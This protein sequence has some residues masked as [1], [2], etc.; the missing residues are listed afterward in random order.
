MSTSNAVT[1]TLLDETAHPGEGR[2]WKVDL[3]KNVSSKPIKVTLMQSQVT[4]RTALS[5]P[6][7]FVRTIAT[8]EAVAKAADEVLVMVGDYAKVVGTYG[9]TEGQS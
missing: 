4:G 5:E 8:P 2:W 1:A 9:L 3:I 7:G 6:I